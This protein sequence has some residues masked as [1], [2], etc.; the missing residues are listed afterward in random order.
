MDLL[1]IHLKWPQVNY[2]GIFKGNSVVEST[3][4]STLRT[5]HYFKDFT[6]DEWEVHFVYDNSL[7]PSLRETYNYQTQREGDIYAPIFQHSSP[8]K[9]VTKTTCSA[10]QGM[11]IIQTLE[12][13]WRKRH[14]PC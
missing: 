11:G 14:V 10:I 4:I 9:P 5:A 7:S 2:F 1:P 8:Q 13:A 6:L 12:V 3:K